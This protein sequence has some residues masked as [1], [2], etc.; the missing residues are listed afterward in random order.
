MVAQCAA[1]IKAEVIRIT[2]L[3]ECGVPITG[4]SSAQVVLDTFT[5]IENSPQ[6]E[7]GQRFLLKKANGQPC[8]NEKD[9]SFLNWLEQ[10]ITLCTLD[11]SAIALVTADRLITDG[12]TGTGV[13]FSDA[14]LQ[15][16]YSV[17]AWQPVSG[18]DACV[19]GG[20]QRYV[21]WA[22][23][24]MYDAKIQDFT[25]ENDVFTFG[26]QGLSKR[27]NPAW[28]LGADWLADGGTWGDQEHFAFNIT[29]VAPPTPA[30]GSV[31][32]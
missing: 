9:P 30:C 13:A 15:G 23:P 29:D 21:Y 22:F 24:H 18:S 1:P 16:R 14:L 5:E 28:D 7:D 17:E 19:P 8:V 12:V 2:A 10:A 31:T 3:D 25:F 26:W 32:I 20:G 4:V 11:P 27:A 6:Y